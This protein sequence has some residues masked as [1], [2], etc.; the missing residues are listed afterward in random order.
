MFTLATMEVLIEDY[1]AHKPVTDLMFPVIERYEDEAEKFSEFNQAIE[2]LEPGI[3]ML[4]VIIDQH[5]LTLSDFKAEIGAKSMVSMI[6]SGKRSL[7]LKH[8]KPLSARFGV[9]TSMFIG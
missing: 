8:I 7:T 9:P 5:K 2:Q 6:L 1:D 3:A 4:R